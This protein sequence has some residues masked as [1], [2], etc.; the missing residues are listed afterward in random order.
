MLDPRS[1]D[2]IDPLLTAGEIAARV[3]RLGRDITAHY[4]D[5]T[6]PLTVLGVM[7]GGLMFCADL[8][9]VLDRPLQLG[10]LHA[11]SYH[12]RS[13]T[14]GELTLAVDM[15]PDLTD[16]HVLLVDD[17]F[18]TGQTLSRIVR[19]LQPRG[20]RSICS[21]VLLSKQVPRIA[22]ADLPTWTGFEI[23]DRFVVGYGLDFD[24]EYRGLPSIGVLTGP[25]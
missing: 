24:G 18:D 2:R 12:G 9:R 3:S 15:L 10:V 19:E 7:T 5:P 14:S 21:A 13:T 8:I 6:E 4:D 23:E 22:D 11:R 16:R 25:G 1:G 17:I 20:C